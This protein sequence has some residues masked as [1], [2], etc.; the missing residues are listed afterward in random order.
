MTYTYIIT[1]IVA[2]AISA[3]ATWNVQNWRYGNIENKRNKQ[4]MTNK[5]KNEKTADKAA[6]AFEVA[7]AKTAEREK[8]VYIEVEKI[9]DRP[10]YSNV[11]ID[12]DGLRQ[13][14]SL[15]APAADSGESQGNVP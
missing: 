8:L 7:K 6:T 10:V 1:A 4:E 14:N 3:T 2:A 9:I 13:L 15:I 12:D 5:D 11:C